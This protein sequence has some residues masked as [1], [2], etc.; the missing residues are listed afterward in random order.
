MEPTV[1]GDPNPFAAQE[2]GAAKKPADAGTPMP[3]KQ[4]PKHDAAKKD[5]G[6]EA[7]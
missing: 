6:K 7:F 2:K 4:S 5:A 3:Q 1:S